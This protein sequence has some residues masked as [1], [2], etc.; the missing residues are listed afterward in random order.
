MSDQLLLSE[1]LSHSTVRIEC[2]MHDGTTSTGSGFFYR[3]AQTSGQHVPAIVTN[4]HVVVGSKVGKFSLTLSS[5]IGMPEM[6]QHVSVQ[7][8]RFE[9]RWIHHPDPDVDLCAMP[10]A[11]LLK[12]AEQI[13]K[14]FFYMSL[15][16]SLLPSVTDLASF[17]TLEDILMVGYPI[18]LWDSINN[19]PI[20]RRGIT[21]TH[22]NIDYEGKREFLIDAACFPGSSGSPVFLF[23]TGN[24][25]K[26]NGEIAMGSTRVRLL[27]ILYAGPQHTATGEIRI[28]TIP[29]NQRAIATSSIPTNL[30]FVIKASRLTE[31]DAIIRQTV[32]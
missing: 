18:G 30:G 15:D 20:F 12:E 31:L 7:M 25:T 13:N 9:E 10:I 28:V 5:T 2:E 24:W 22:P 23:N 26:R 27:G 32:P 16:E 17:G 4:K 1:K 11:P 6:G 3:F 21:A 14:P 8:E 19:M 29:T